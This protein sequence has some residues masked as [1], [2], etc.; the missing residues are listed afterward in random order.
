MKKRFLA[1]LLVFSMV[2]SMMPL[3]VLAA[4]E[5]YTVKIPLVGTQWIHV[6]YE[7]ITTETHHILR[8]QCKNFDLINLE[9]M[10]DPST[11]ECIFNASDYGYDI[12]CDY[13]CEHP[14]DEVSEKTCTEDSVCGV[15]GKVLEEAGHDFKDAT[16]TEP[17]KCK[18]C[19]EVGVGA[20]G[21][22]NIAPATCTKQAVCENCG[23]YGELEDHEYEDSFDDEY[24]FEKCENCPATKNEEKHTLIAGKCL[25]CDYEYTCEHTNAIYANKNT[26]EDLLDLADSIPLVGD[27]VAT[28]INEVIAGIDYENYH[29]I[30]CQDCYNVG[31]EEHNLSK[32]TFTA[33]QTCE[34][35]YTLG[36]ALTVLVND[37]TVTGDVTLEL[38]IN[39]TV[40][41]VS[42]KVTDGMGGYLANFD[43][44]VSDNATL[45]SLAEGTYEVTVTAN[46][47]TFTFNITV[48]PYT[49]PTLE[50]VKEELKELLKEEYEN[51]KEIIEDKIEESELGD[52]YKALKE[53]DEKDI[54]TLRK[55]LEEVNEENISA[56]LELAK[57]GVGLEDLAKI[58]EILPDLTLEELSDLLDLVAKLDDGI[59]E[60]VKLL[61]KV[62]TSELEEILDELNKID[63]SKLEEILDALENLDKEDIEE[64]L[65][66]LKDKTEQEI[67]D[68]ASE[69][70]G[71]AKEEIKAII[72]ALK[73]K[74]D[75]V[76]DELNQLEEKLKEEIEKLLEDAFNNH[77]HIYK[78]EDANNC[79]CV[80]PNCTE[81]KAHS[82]EEATFNYDIDL[83]DL[84]GDFDIELVVGENIDV[85]I[86]FA[87]SVEEL[88]AKLTELEEKIGQENLDKAYALLEKVG[89][90]IVGFKN[91]LEEYTEIDFSALEEKIESDLANLKSK[92]ENAEFSDAVDL[93]DLYC[94]VKICRT[95]LHIDVVEHVESD[96]I[97]VS[98]SEHIT[99]C[100]NEGCEKEFLREE[101][102]LGEYVTTSSTHKK[103]C[104]KCD[105]E[106][107]EE[108]HEFVECICK[109]CDYECT[110]EGETGDT[111]SVCGK[112]LSDDEDDDNNNGDNEDNE[113]EEDV[114]NYE[115]SSVK[116]NGNNATKSN[117]TFS[118]GTLARGTKKATVTF[119]LD[120][121][122]LDNEVKVKVDNKEVSFSGNELSIEIDGLSNGTN[123]K[124]VELIVN[125][126]TTKTYTLSISV[127]T[128]SGS[129]SGGGSSSGSGRAPAAQDLLIVTTEVGSAA[130]LTTKNSGVITISEKYTDEIIQ[131]AEGKVNFTGSAVASPSVTSIKFTEKL[132]K[133]LSEREDSKITEI[134][135]DTK[136]ASMRVKLSEVLNKGDITITVKEVTTLTNAQKEVANGAKLYDVEIKSSKLGVIN[137]F[138]KNVEI[139]LPY[140]LKEGEDIDTITMYSVSK[141]GSTLNLRGTYNEGTVYSLVKELGNPVMVVVN[142]IKFVDYIAPT[143]AKTYVDQMASKNILLGSETNSYLPEKLSV[144]EFSELLNNLLGVNQEVLTSESNI[145]RSEVAKLI[146][147]M[148]EGKAEY[149]VRL[150]KTAD[151]ED[152][153][154]VSENHETAVEF[155]ARAGI[156]VGY[157]DDTLR[158]DRELTRTE[159]AVIFTKIFKIINVF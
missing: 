95:C 21:H 11:G 1:L 102:E 146:S 127:R 154:E 58:A 150:T 68:F 135:V 125:G 88:K 51:W 123:S 29:V 43:V 75:E 114:V 157:T 136:D 131:K 39:E 2:F 158:P 12:G 13:K 26:V 92:I 112:D 137:K 15:C 14:E 155:V 94:S 49:A 117:S 69:I 115:I 147:D 118:Y 37:E 67:K 159:A 152:S 5:C 122:L 87:T 70:E 121:E 110:H 52:L 100:E 82:Y 48:E 128:S 22:K 140:E 32:A 55:L 45:D 56:I 36:E 76:K 86:D 107:E 63:T 139:T 54:E 62:D 89:I 8:C 116:V 10:W 53:F 111:C 105:Y 77:T 84:A 90:G 132:L 79:K 143:W 64:A 27:T 151:F 24:H 133:E 96:F 113:N 106:T 17:Q 38:N 57:D 47:D 73:E 60:I 138:N 130:Q 85:D 61:E 4:D 31:V 46:E 78:Y 80:V 40:K 28:K 33:P 16:C 83:K 156:M 71:K 50:D 30:L 42:L 120:S 35:E 101:H 18:N 142:P 93:N 126:E 99:K 34:C 81:T 44:E 91:L 6:G 20:T 124:A 144:K 9:H 7:L 97:S 23:S 108:E 65:E 98:A 129:S 72:E 59:D 104:E 66:N 148:M 153:D 145:T 19:P 141:E 41:A 109:D 149:E 119:T 74:Q 25:F 134:G 103:E 3:E